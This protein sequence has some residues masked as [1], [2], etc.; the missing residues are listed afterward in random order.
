[1]LE[2]QIGER[3]FKINE[4]APERRCYQEDVMEVLNAEHIKLTASTK[5]ADRVNIGWIAIP[6]GIELTE[7]K[8]GELLETLP[9]W[10]QY[11][12]GSIE[13]EEERTKREHFERA[14]QIKALE[15][16]A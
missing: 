13:T 14:Q 15:K 5:L 11:D 2:N 4:C 12:R 9:C 6:S 1:M 16:V 3:Y 7:K 8:V 10:D